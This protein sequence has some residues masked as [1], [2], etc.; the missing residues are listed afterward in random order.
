MSDC[1][2]QPKILGIIGSPRKNGNT[3]RLVDA[4]LGG[5]KAQ[6]A[7]I[8]KIYLSD[9]QFSSC[10]A[11]E[12]CKTAGQCTLDDD[13]SKIV[14]KM[15]ESDIWVLGTPVY[16]WGPTGWFKSFVDRWYGARHEF[17]FSTKKAVI[18]IP[19]EDTNIKTGR[20]T[21]GMLKDALDY[22]KVEII[23]TL[24]APGLLYKDDTEKDGFFLLEAEKIGR[25]I[26]SGCECHTQ[27]N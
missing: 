25:A 21:E 26:F 4:V 16:F 27:S 8:D 7:L 3:D 19:F 13:Y 9:L 12:A 14:S 22:M 10:T 17:D 6:N 20:H 15:A 24:M 5:A 1:F 18:V 2:K 11:C 23:A